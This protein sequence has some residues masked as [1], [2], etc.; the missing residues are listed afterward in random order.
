MGIEFFIFS[1][2]ENVLKIDREQP[3]AVMHGLLR[4]ARVTCLKKTKPT[5]F[6]KN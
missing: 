1:V 3:H 6:L 4:S 2:D 5:K